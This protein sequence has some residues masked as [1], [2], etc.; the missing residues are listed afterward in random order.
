VVFFGFLP[1]SD[2]AASSYHV[3]QLEEQNGR[4]KEALVRCVVMSH[5]CLCHVASFH[6]TINRVKKSEE[7]E[8][9]QN[10]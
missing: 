3:R 7:M 10:S 8:I 1:G 4:L 5:E 2:G 9:R 6:L